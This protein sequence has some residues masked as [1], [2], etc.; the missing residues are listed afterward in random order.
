MD[1]VLGSIG[2]AARVCNVMPGSTDCAVSNGIIP[3]SGVFADGKEVPAPV[4]APIVGAGLPGL[5]FAGL[6]GWWRRRKKIA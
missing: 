1:E 2:T 6:F 5:I 3:T 4:P